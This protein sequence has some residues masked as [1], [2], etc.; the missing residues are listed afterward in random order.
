MSR[1]TR[2]SSASP[3]A[4]IT[5]MSRTLRRGWNQARLVDRELMAL[6]TKLSRHAGW[7]GAGPVEGSPAL[8]G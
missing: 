7:N 1:A 2:T 4:K 5:R 8:Q 3:T 6:R